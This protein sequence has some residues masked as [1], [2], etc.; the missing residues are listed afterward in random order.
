MREQPAHMTRGHGLL[1]PLLARLRAKQAD[2]L[3][4][5]DLRKGRILDIGSG[6]Y[7]YFLSHTY[8][9]EKFA[10]DQLEKPQNVADV[11]W[12]SLDLNKTTALPFDG[13]Y[14]DVVTMLAVVEHLDPN[15]LQTL[16]QE[17]HRILRVGGR[18]IITTP[19]AW[20]DGLLQGMARTGLVS[21]EE[22]DEHVF[23]YTLPLLGWYFGRAGF[24]MTKVKFGYFE[25]H[26]NL[27]ATAD[28]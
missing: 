19:A 3:V 18:L 10:V 6:T 12:H 25:F 11:T 5:E 9:A 23:V 4:P 17:V 1:E 2:A 14:F 20:S 27:W 16:F 13:Q 21:K 24:E 28:R 26:L 8:F 22:I 7:P 15:G